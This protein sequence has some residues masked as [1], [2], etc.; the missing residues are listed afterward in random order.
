MAGRIYRPR[1]AQRILVCGAVRAE[2]NGGV[3]A[4][5]LDLSEEGVR[6]EHRKIVRPGQGYIVELA[7][8][9]LAAPLRLP[10]Q[11]IWSW[12]HRF[13]AGQ[14]QPLVYQSGLKFD[15][16]PAEAHELLGNVL[17]ELAVPRQALAT[18]EPVSS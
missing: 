17:A 2:V 10:A 1:R 11:V 9:G 18:R 16:L 6:I 15:T 7:L 4:S 13:E 5:V 3:E 14:E 8:P 12:V